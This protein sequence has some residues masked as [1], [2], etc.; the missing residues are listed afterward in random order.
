RRAAGHGE[1]VHLGV[2]K[3]CAV[4]ALGDALDVRFEILVTRDRQVVAKIGG[5]AYLV[6]MVLTAEVGAVLMLNDAFEDLLLHFA[7]MACGP[8]KRQQPPADRNG[9]HAIN[10]RTYEPLEHGF[11]DLSDKKPRMKHG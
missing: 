11:T 4:V 3:Q 10:E 7:R 8:L 1:H 6:E 5:R 2:G 9:R